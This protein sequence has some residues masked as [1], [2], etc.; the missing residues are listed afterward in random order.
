[1]ERAKGVKTVIIM[2]LYV[3]GT[4]VCPMP[5]RQVGCTMSVPALSCRCNMYEAVPRQ[6]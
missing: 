6:G 3:F 4:Q 5:Y 1:M 2:N